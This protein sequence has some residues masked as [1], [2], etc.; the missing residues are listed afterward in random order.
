MLIAGLS[1]LFV[2]AALGFALKHNWQN[3]RSIVVLMALFIITIAAIMGFIRYLELADT[4][5]LHQA[6]S[7]A[8]KHLAMAAFLIGLLWRCFERPIT[9]YCLLG[10]ALAGFTLNIIEPMAI[11]S[12]GFIVLLSLYLIYQVRANKPALTQSLTGLTLLL[13]TLIWGV[14][15]QDESLLTG[16]FHLCLGSFIILITLAGN[17]LRP[18]K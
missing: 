11:I 1:E 14:L 15:I 5:A 17:A 8:G 18:T 13:S 7:F 12:D 2:L 3:K 4:Q 9:P 6:L 10:V 16:V